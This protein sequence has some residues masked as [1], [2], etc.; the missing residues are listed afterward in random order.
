[1]DTFLTW[2]CSS[3][4]IISFCLFILFIPHVHGILQARIPRA[5]VDH[6]WS[7]LFTMTHP[8]WV[9]LHSMARSFIELHKPLC[10]NKAVIHEGGVYT[11]IHADIFIYSHIYVRASHV[12]QLVKNL[13]A[14][15]GDMGLIPELGKSPGGGNGNPLQ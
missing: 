13:P 10:H 8:F 5:P 9:A 12:M 15:I 11:Y 1:M 14:N 2:G 3:S 4:S 7:E 6:I